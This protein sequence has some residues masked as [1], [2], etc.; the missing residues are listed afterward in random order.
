M[1]LHEHLHELTTV[2]LLGT[3][4]REPPALIDVPD[5][6]QHPIR[7]V[8]DLVADAQRTTPSQRLLAQ[9]AGWAV[10]QRSGLI[11]HPPVPCSLPAPDDPRPVTPESATGTW[12]RIV[13]DWS[14]L[15]DEWLLS[16]VSSGRRLAPE[17]VPPVLARNRTDRTRHRRALLAAGPLGDWMIEWSPRLAC[18]AGGAGAA[19]RAGEIEVATLP[20]LPL[21]PEVAALL[22]ASAANVSEAF[23][24]SLSTGAWAA[25]HRG[26]LVNFVARVTPE[27]LPTLITALDQVDPSSPSIGLAFALADLARLRQHMLTELEPA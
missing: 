20:A 12:K 5:D 9:V 7:M 10:A 22:G 11:P 4:R 24:R 1:N 8:A 26:V 15:E 19:T 16:V 3:D 23:L 25:S 21:V 27:V 2:A 18:S 6:L 13:A 17:L 14:V